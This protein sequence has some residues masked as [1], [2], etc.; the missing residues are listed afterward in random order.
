MVN[1]TRYNLI[2]LMKAEID[3]NQNKLKSSFCNLNQGTAVVV[4][5]S[6]EDKAEI[7]D[8]EAGGSEVK[9]LEIKSD[10]Q[11]VELRDDNNLNRVAI[12]N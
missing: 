7:E 5:S 1:H 3:E 2:K 6:L 10:D 9:E 8:K 11:D 12:M 4:S